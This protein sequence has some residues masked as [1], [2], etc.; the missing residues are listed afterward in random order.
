MYAIVQGK[1]GLGRAL[2]GPR[3]GRACR[4]PF[5]GHRLGAPCRTVNRVARD[6]VA[7]G[8]VLNGKVSEGWG[9]GEVRARRGCGDLESGTKAVSADVSSTQILPLPCRQG[10]GARD[11]RNPPAHEMI[12]S[13][14]NCPS[15]IIHEMAAGRKLHWTG[16]TENLGGRRGAR[17]QQE[18]NSSAQCLDR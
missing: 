3:T 14:L 2:G 13:S 18:Q 11:N 7:D 4:R 8:R 16:G 6:G 5:S 9:A 17:H 15:K 10:W 12:R 1:G